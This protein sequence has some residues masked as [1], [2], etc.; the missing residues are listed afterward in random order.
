[1]ANKI[2]IRPFVLDCY[3]AALENNQFGR[4]SG[5]AQSM[6]DNLKSVAREMWETER[7]RFGSLLHIPAPF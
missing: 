6:T 7:Q 3:A 5:L 1:M 4:A 2:Y